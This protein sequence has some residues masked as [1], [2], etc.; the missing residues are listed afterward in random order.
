MLCDRCNENAA[1]IH[2]KKIIN[3]KIMEVHLCEQCA[4]ETKEVETDNEIELSLKDFLVELMDLTLDES[5]DTTDVSNSYE[6]EIKCE[7]CGITYTEFKEKG[8]FGCTQCLSTF[9]DIMPAVLKKLHG[10]VYH[11]GKVPMK[12]RKEMNQKRDVIDLKEKLDEA[13]KLEEY[14][15]AA[16]LRD[17]IRSLEKEHVNE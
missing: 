4:K 9:G 3:G 1:N 12:Y 16:E 6:D 14:E 17:K 2:I 11:E 15:M 8:K 13:I 5:S 7:N 10:S